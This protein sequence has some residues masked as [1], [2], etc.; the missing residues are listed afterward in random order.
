MKEP[1]LKTWRVYLV[2]KTRKTYV[3]VRA[4]YWRIDNGA[5]MFRI[6]NAGGYPI[7]VH[8]F[9]PGVWS[10]VCEHIAGKPR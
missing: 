9:A 5:A 10:D 1:V 6:N 7:N 8:T 4:E 2:G 3:K